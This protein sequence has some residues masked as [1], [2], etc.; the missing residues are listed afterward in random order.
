MLQAQMPE[1]V[2]EVEHQPVEEPPDSTPPVEDPR[3]GEPVPTSPIPER[4]LATRPEARPSRVTEPVC[5]SGN[6]GEQA[7]KHIIAVGRY[8]FEVLATPLCDPRNVGRTTLKVDGAATM[9]SLCQVAST[10][11]HRRP[12]MRSWLARTGLAT[13][14]LV[15]SVALGY[16][17][18]PPVPTV[19]PGTQ[20]PP[21]AEIKPSHPADGRPAPGGPGTDVQRGPQTEFPAPL[22]PGVRP[23]TPGGTT[24]DGVARPPES[25]DPGINKGTPAPTLFPTPVI[26]PPG[27]PSRWRE[28]V[29]SV[30]LSPSTNM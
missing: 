26:P 1:P 19:P 16:S 10:S 3:P 15:G 22:P 30:R 6:Y 25:V 13:A 27:A 14:L 23:D 7:D 5:C 24:S 18:A 4:L 20:P 2:P 9:Q 8:S 12:Y 29:E 28:S 17:Q 11:S 21:P